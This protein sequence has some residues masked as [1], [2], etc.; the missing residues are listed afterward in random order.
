MQVLK[1]RNNKQ[2]ALSLSQS[3]ILG[4]EMLVVVMLFFYLGLS[5][6]SPQK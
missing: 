5:F 4:M 1:R 2:T 6:Q 3:S